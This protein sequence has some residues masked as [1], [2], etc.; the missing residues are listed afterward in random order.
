MASQSGVIKLTSRAVDVTQVP[1]GLLG[2]VISTGKEPCETVNLY[3]GA[4][5]VLPFLAGRHARM[6]LEFRGRHCHPGCAVTCCLC[7]WRLTESHR[8]H[9]SIIQASCR[10]HCVLD[11]RTSKQSCSFI[12]RAQTNAQADCLASTRESVNNTAA[13]PGDD[14]LRCTE[15]MFQAREKSTVSGRAPPCPRKCGSGTP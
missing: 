9:L 13:R 12:D 14:R 10:W 6:A 7:A 8:W 4:H 1:H 3:H 5:R 11:Q 15:N 2:A